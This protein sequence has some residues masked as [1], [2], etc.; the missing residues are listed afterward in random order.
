MMLVVGGKIF[1]GYTFQSV[2]II[3]SSRFYSARD[4]WIKLDN[5]YPT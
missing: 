5:A 3:Y 4:D 2:Y 1:A